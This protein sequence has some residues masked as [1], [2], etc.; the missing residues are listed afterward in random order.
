MPLVHRH[1]QQPE[2]R[3]NTIPSLP[4]PMCLSRPERPKVKE[5]RA[6]K[7]KKGESKGRG[8]GTGKSRG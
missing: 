3:A 6:G 2:W 1:W 8:R 7:S 4:R 5:T